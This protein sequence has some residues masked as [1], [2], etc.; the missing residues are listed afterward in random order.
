MDS[1]LECFTFALNALGSVVM[2]SGFRDVTDA[3]ALKRI[4]P[5]EILG[6]TR[7][8]PP[9]PPRAGYQ[10]VFPTVQRTWL[11]E[12]KLIDRIRDLHDVSKH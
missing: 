9:K 10:A 7:T 11:K 8:T 12:Q 3:K 2:P 4:E 6:D 1:A 5:S